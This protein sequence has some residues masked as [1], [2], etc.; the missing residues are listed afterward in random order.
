MV[1]FECEIPYPD[2]ENPQ[3]WKTPTF[4]C[5]APRFCADL[6]FKQIFR[7]ERKQTLSRFIRTRKITITLW[8][9][10][11][12][13][14]DICLGRCEVRLNEL[15]VK[16]SIEVKTE[17]MDGRKSTG[18]SI[19]VSVRLRNPV[20]VKETKTI[21]EKILFIDKHFTQED[22]LIRKI[23]KH[24]TVP[25]P[26]TGKRSVINSA[27]NLKFPDMVSR[28]RKQTPAEA[29]K[30]LLQY[31]K[32]PKAPAK[33]K[34]SD[35]AQLKIK[36][37]SIHWI[38]SPAVLEQEHMKLN[39]QI[40]FLSQNNLDHNTEDKRLSEISKKNDRTHG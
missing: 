38:I 26:T 30:Q 10:R 20:E 22:L 35:P 19:F 2:S 25:S 5:A 4:P 6:N 12:L 7:I 16:S 18:A 27:E 9:Y 21:K 29:Q 17:V 28:G 32:N 24:A 36:T 8:H 14:G 40:L 31:A 1:Y 37:E 11:F 34:E 13:L 15:A 3:A 33:N 23:E 39:E